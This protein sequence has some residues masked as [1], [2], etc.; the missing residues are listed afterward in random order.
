MAEPFERHAKR[1]EG[2]V[3]RV[4]GGG[5]Q[6]GT[7]A[8]IEGLLADAA[9]VRDV[10]AEHVRQIAVRHGVDLGA[11]LLPAR[12]NLYRRLLEQCVLDGAVSAEENAEL[13]HLKVILGLAD[14]DVA[15]VHE[16][17]ARA[18]YGQALGQALEDHRIDPD[19]RAFLARLQSDLHLD[20]ETAE[21]LRE[22]E[23]ELSRQR[24]LSRSLTYDNVL[25]STRAKLELSGSSDK[26]LEDAIREA[27][28]KAGRAVP[29]L[30]TA[31]VESIRTD[32][33]GGRVARWHV[34]LRASLRGPR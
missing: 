6:A 19:E 9:R 25:V 22:R 12:R 4:L 20:P 2:L 31:E 10:S 33:D 5:A 27:I 30:A 18:A 21:R 23:A 16:D 8:E 26:S 29:E 32:V 15:P 14:A 11:R 3:S 7:I 24:F 28:E 1:R 13:A 34:Q 17:V